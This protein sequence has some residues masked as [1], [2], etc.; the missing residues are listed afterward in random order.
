MQKK[1]FGPYLIIILLFITITSKTEAQDQNPTAVGTSNGIWIYLGDEIPSDF[2]YQ[3]FRKQGNGNFNLIGTTRFPADPKTL[4]T[5]VEKFNALFENLDKL[6]DREVA[7]IQNFASKNKTTDTIIMSNLPVMHL[8]FGTAYFDSDVK[9]GNTYQYRVR[10]INNQDAQVWERASNI[11]EYPA[12]TDILKPLFKDKEEST[13][14]IMLRWYVTIQKNLNSFAVFRRVF[15]TGDFIRIKAVKGYN[16]SLDTVYLI[17]IDTIVKN[18]AVYEYYIGPLDIYGNQGPVSDIV[19]AGTIGNA[20]NPV[21]DY[22]RA[23]GLDK[24]HKVELIWHFRDKKYLRGIEVYRSTS[25]DSGFSRIAQLAS[26][27]TTYTDVVNEANQNYWY[28]LV[29]EG[30]VSKSLPTAKVSVMF[31]NTGEKPI[32]PEETGAESIKGGV[33]IYWS[34]HEPY[35]KGFYVYRYVYERAEYNQVSGL[36]PAGSELYSFIDSSASIRGNETYRYAV[37]TVNDVDQVSDFSP[38]ASASPGIK[39]SVRSPEN[40]R[41]TK[42]DKGILLIW[43]DLR[44]AEPQLLGYKIYRKIVPEKTFSLLP[45]DTLRS[46]KNYYSDTTLL[47]GKTY[48]YSVTAID[49]YGNQSAGSNTVTFSLPEETIIPPEIY[50][51]VN[52]TDGIMISWGQVTDDNVSSVK[53]Y[54]ADPGRQPAVITTVNKDTDQYLDKNV[55]KGLLYIYQISLV[56]S[57]NLESEKSRGISV[58][59]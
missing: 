56:T 16:T 37:R 43:D 20:Y 36:I 25:F 54:R 44:N 4:Q 39:E 11:L 23:K 31:R 6:G 1:L 35:A 41:I 29:I 32:P 49:F 48:I 10:K 47:P 33:K 27:D 12:K 15:G 3:I 42:T 51:A 50:K 40:P 19:V 45:N 26:T 5:N 14:Q 57:G 46:D 7:Y 13:S 8:A 55:K 34:Y 24:D 30:P 38:S 9:P 18:P 17:A 2:Q 52:T 58:R 28:Y 21:P 53:L 59:R 22:F